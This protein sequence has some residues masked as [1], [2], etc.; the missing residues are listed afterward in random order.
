MDDGVPSTR[1]RG[2]F[3]HIDTPELDHVEHESAEGISVRAVTRRR[4]ARP[5]RVA[6]PNTSVTASRLKLDDSAARSANGTD[7]RRQVRTS[8]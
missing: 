1:R 3:S 8:R 5:I 2:M 7:N 6:L 4:P